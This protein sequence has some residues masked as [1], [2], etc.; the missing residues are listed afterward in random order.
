M[1][2]VNKGIEKAAK[3]N[4]GGGGGGAGGKRNKPRPPRAFAEPTDITM[5]VNMPKNEKNRAPP[6]KVVDPERE[7]PGL[8]AARLEGKEPWQHD[9][10][11]HGAGGRKNPHAPS[12]NGTKLL[13]SNLDHNVTKEDIKELFE[14]IGRLKSYNVHYDRFDR[15]EGTA[16]VVFADRALAVVAQKKYHSIELDGKPMMIEII[17]QKTHP[18]HVLKSGI[19]L[20]AGGGRVVQLPNA[21]SQAFSDAVK[22]QPRGRGSIRSTVETMQMD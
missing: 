17:E 15:S 3:K 6:R 2:V 19:K 9:M 14:T 13:I 20:G 1:K 10:H 18:E 8:R 16:E 5:V 11:H 4:R 7:N 12:L 21:F 22:P